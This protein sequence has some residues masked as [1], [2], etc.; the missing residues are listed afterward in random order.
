MPAV[1]DR[2]LLLRRFPYGESSLV[3]HALSRTHGRVHLLAKGAYRP[4]SRFYAALDLFDT[5][6]LEWNSAPGREL[7]LLAAGEIETRR[8]RIAQDLE[9]FHAATTLLELAGFGAHE[10]H[11]NPELFDLLATGLD[12]LA[13]G[14]VPDAAAVE[15][16]LG[17]LHNLGLAPALAAC[18]SCGGA[19]PPLEPGP[20]ARVAFS[21]GSGGRLCSACADAA[22]AAGRRVGTLPSAVLERAVEILARRVSAC[23]L[24]PDELERVRD[25]VARFLEVHLESRP[26]SYRRFLSA[27][28]RN[29][30]P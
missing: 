27:P 12:A 3:C 5:L 14:V 16:E 24:D 10:G 17:L 4:T 7:A 28:N 2:A 25:F 18:A 29:A 11:A 22:R 13:R 20:A 23:A 9:A 21:A 26:A 19:A 1:R 15:F 8:A 6:E 30:R